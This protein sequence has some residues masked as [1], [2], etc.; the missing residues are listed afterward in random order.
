MGVGEEDSAGGEEETISVQ[1]QG[2]TPRKIW[3]AGLGNSFRMRFVPC[4]MPFLL[5]PLKC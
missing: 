4:R 2:V 5:K 3:T 1:Q